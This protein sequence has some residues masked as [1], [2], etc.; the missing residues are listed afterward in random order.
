MTNISKKA[1]S[2]EQMS[3]LSGQLCATAAKLT[4]TTAPDFFNEFLGEEERVM[5]AKRLGAIMLCISGES[6]Y[7]IWTTLNISPTTTQKIYDGYSLGK[8]DTLEKILKKNR[9][10]YERF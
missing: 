7:R 3:K 10:E 8:Y 4:K 1:L 2:T 6:Q 9:F 5:L